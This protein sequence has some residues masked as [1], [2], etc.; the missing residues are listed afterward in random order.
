MC[1]LKQVFQECIIRIKGYIIYLITF[2]WDTGL[3][4]TQ[5]FPF[6]EKCVW[7]LVTLADKVSKLTLR[8]DFASH[9]TFLLC[10]KSNITTIPGHSGI[11]LL[12]T[13]AVKVSDPWK[14]ALRTRN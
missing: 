6:L 1:T 4:Y 5:F 12:R 10:S 13:A 9:L 14:A 3:L 2:Q 7:V 11:A 8:A